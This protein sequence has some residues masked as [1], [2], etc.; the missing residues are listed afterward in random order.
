VV[1][2]ETGLLAAPH[3]GGL[4]VWFRRGT[5]PTEVSGRPGTSSSDYGRTAREF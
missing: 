5:A 4:E 1:D 2:R 3:A